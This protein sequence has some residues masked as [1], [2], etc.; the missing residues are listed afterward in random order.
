MSTIFYNTQHSPIGAFASFTLG[1]KGAKG[2][3]G[4]ELTK[5]ADQNV[6]IGLEGDEAFSCLPFCDSV[7][8]ES[9]RFDVEAGA[10]NNSKIK[11]KNFP[12]N[13][14]TRTLSLAK[15]SWRAGD[16]E[17]SIFSPVIPAPDPA[18]A[19]KDE[20]M[21]AYVP[22]IAVTMTVDNRASNKSRRA[23]FG[24][25]SN[26]PCRGM[27]RLDETADGLFVGIASGD[28]TA[29]A[30]KS[31]GVFSAQA[32]TAEDILSEQY[33]LN[34][35]FVL[36]AVGLLVGIVPPKKRVTFEFV[37]CFHRNGKATT[38]MD[39]KYFYTRF[40]P[41]IESV[42]KYALEN[43]TAVQQRSDLFDRTL[44]RSKLNPSRKFMLAQ[45]IHSY[46]ASTELLDV[47]GRILWAVNEGE[48]RMLNTFDLTVDQLFF[49]MELNPWT[50]RNE[51]EW[52][53][54]RYSYVDTVR[55]PGDDTEYPGGIS[56]THDMGIANHF[57][58]PQYSAY[59]K[60]G[61]D[62]CF[63]H[64][65]HEELVNW[66][67]CGLVYEAKTHDSAWLKTTLPVFHKT[68]T[69]LLNRDHPDPAQRDGV[70]SLDSSRCSGGAEITTYDSLDVSLGQARNNLYLAVKC[71]G[72]YVGLAA[73][74]ER[75]GDDKRA[76]ICRDQARRAADT[77]AKSADSDGL[78]PA[79]LNENVQSRIIPAVEGLIIPY[80]LGLT[81][82]LSPKGAYGEMIAA[83]KKH[84]VGVLRPGVCLFP[85]GAW[86]I[87]STS[88]NS[89]LS[90]VYLCQFIAEKILKC[91]SKD[92]MEVA[93]N[94][95]AGWLLEESNAYWAWSD[96]M[97]NGIARGSKYYPRGA[98][99]ILWLR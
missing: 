8:D 85:N 84:L 48:Y 42:A 92:Q 79:I 33:P 83:L 1:A 90:K 78:L 29:I 91:V 31:L 56:F 61:L 18:T 35:A 27:R 26:E 21:G 32:F 44:S 30:T 28:S 19:A 96:Q 49:E 62:G 24:F 87:S 12:D 38:G 60:T 93:D 95:H 99:S 9:T 57:S 2:G 63:S 89:W 39:T 36:G 50:V 34:R 76:E 88:D 41:D 74:F 51:L 17:F 98:T 43:F 15:D 66:V 97:V 7:V 46:Y 80:E 10:E 65:T 11:L 13:Q 22:A 5:P 58:R 75:L 67:A 16:L 77:V 23:F 45:A 14:I 4:L 64:M 53:V 59:E 81:D 6:F 86:K 70:M 68:L 94:S 72:C 37:V 55:F 73:L 25:Q 3:L 52:F 40:F 47:R 54:K 20:L 82:A 69:S 71:W